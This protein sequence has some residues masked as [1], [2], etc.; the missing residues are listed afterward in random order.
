MKIAYITEW[1]V[2]EPS[3]VLRKILGQV[4][5]WKEADH[6]VNLYSIAPLQDRAAAL[7]F[8][9]HGEIFGTLR[10]TQLKRFPYARLGFF[11]KILTVP[12]LSIEV[13]SFQPDL[14]YYRQQG[15]WYPGIGKILKV[16][17]AIAELNGNFASEAV[18]GRTNSTFRSLTEGLLW[19]HLSGFV[20]VSHDI[21]A[22]Y[23]FLEKPIEVVSNSLWRQPRAAKPSGNTKPTFVFVGSRLAD[24]GAW[25]GVDKIMQLARAMPDS[26]F[27]IVGLSKNDV[28][29]VTAPPNIVFHGPIYGSKLE[30]IYQTSD[31]GIGTLALHRKAMETNSALKPLEYLSFGLPVILGYRE[32]EDRLNQADYSLNIGNYENNVRDGIE[33]IKD[34]GD[35]WCGKRVEA[36]LG[37]LSAKTIESQRLDFMQRVAITKASKAAAS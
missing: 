23:A 19:R 33:Q 32:T 26:F 25:H 35:K 8:D 20:S 37:Y 30:E 15:P 28:G 1:P 24:G 31:I 9:A 3:G 12:A 7:N 34:F 14:I 21:A 4:Q 17:P 27:N 6:Q 2:Y 11:N 5:A 22:E 13:K 16:A 10:Q 36:D 29:G 18:W